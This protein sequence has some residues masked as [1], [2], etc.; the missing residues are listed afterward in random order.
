MGKTKSSILPLILITSLFP[1]V[2][3]DTSISFIF[4]HFKILIFMFELFVSL[5]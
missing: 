3:Y 1:F 2:K 5:N 4:W